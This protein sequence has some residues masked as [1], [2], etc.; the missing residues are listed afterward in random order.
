MHLS[1]S[2]FFKSHLI[3]LVRHVKQPVKV[4]ER[5][6]LLCW[7]DSGDDNK[8]DI[9]CFWQHTWLIFFPPV[10]VGYSNGPFQQKGILMRDDFSCVLFFF[11][12]GTIAKTSRF[13]H[14]MFILSSLYTLLM[15][16]RYDI[17]LYSINAIYSLSCIS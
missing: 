10:S 17:H 8:L 12:F 3:F 13:Q 5:L 9:F 2:G 7:T 6:E 1:H 15:S 11:F 14:R 16:V 4:L